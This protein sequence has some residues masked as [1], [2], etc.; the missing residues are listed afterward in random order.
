ML[1]KL[2]TKKA[3]LGQEKSNFIFASAAFSEETCQP[4]FRREKLRFFSRKF[5][6]Q[7]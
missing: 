7:I 6:Q 2:G 5:S 3:F 1:E 4:S